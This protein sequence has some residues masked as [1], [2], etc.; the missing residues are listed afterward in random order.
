MARQVEV[1][2]IG[3]C[4]VDFLALVLGAVPCL[5]SVIRPLTV[6]RPRGTGRDLVQGA[7]CIAGGQQEEILATV[8]IWCYPLCLG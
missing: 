5:A 6:C 4:R 8:P 1:V 3:S 7:E 2:G